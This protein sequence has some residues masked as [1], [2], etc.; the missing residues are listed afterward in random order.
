V[1]LI[2]LK[3]YTYTGTAGKGKEVPIPDDM[4]EAVDEAREA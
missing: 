3:A 4:K 1:D 2:A